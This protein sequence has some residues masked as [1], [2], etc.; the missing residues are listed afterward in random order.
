MPLNSKQKELIEAYKD[1]DYKV[2]SPAIIIT[3]GKL[4][5]DLDKLVL[6]NNE[7]DW[8]YI[9]SCNPYGRDCSEDENKNYYESLLQHVSNNKYFE[10][11]GQGIDTIWPAEKSILIIGMSASQAIEIGNKYNQNAILVGKY[12]QAAELKLLDAFEKVS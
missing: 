4:N 9:T 8:T 3:V 6:E 12:E 7:T 10:G 1:T 11:E 2:Y 5:K